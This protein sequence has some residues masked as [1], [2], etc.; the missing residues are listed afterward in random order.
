MAHT[1]VALDMTA[2]E[3]TETQMRALLH[4]WWGPQ[5]DASGRRWYPPRGTQG[6]LI[7]R[8]WA[9]MQDGCSDD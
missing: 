4:Y 6:A 8:G 2:A 1:G 9:V 5:K 3:P 7:Q